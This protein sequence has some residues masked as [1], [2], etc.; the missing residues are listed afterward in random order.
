MKNL[1]TLLLA[2]LIGLTL[3]G[4]D[5]T[6]KVVGEEESAVAGEYRPANKEGYDRIETT[7]ILELI[8]EQRVYGATCGERGYFAP[9]T[10]LEP[11]EALEDTAYAKAVNLIEYQVFSHALQGALKETYDNVF[12]LIRSGLSRNTNKS[13]E[14][15]AG[16]QVTDAEVVK[17]WMKSDGH[18]AN[19]MDPMYDHVGITHVYE[20][21]SKYHHYYVQ[22]FIA[23]IT[24]R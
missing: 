23:T 10:P 5:D 20:H 12:N 17:A 24:Y 14:N 8:N 13:G 4:C 15:I 21:N 11:L 1:T 16:G 6:K 7:G 22:H 19:I 18:C 3:I 2:I 9:T